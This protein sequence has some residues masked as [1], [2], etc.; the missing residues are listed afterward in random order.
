MTYMY[1]AFSLLGLSREVLNYYES[2]IIYFG[3]VN[4]INVTRG[5][6]EMVK[7]GQPVVGT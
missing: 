6:N 5:E 7:L 2:C 3:T 4:T 1:L